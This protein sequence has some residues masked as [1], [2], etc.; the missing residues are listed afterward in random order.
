MPLPLA[1]T[2]A[3][4]VQELPGETLVYDLA[5]Q[6]AHCL[7]RTAGLVWRHCDGRSTPAEIAAAVGRELGRPTDE[8]LVR[9]ALEQLGRRH[10]LQTPPA[11]PPEA[12]RRQRRALLKALVKAGAVAAAVPVIM[13]I[14][15]PKAAAQVSPSHPIVS[16]CVPGAPCTTSLQ[17]GI[18]AAGI[19]GNCLPS[20][21]GTGMGTCSC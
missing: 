9:L 18:T 13:S 21:T 20:V 4:N 8:V 6:K 15:A 11:P 17:C 5:R 19:S 7:N 16:T 12:A 10:L 2:D 3:L 14:T 1:R